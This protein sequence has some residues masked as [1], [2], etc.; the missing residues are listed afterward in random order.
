VWALVE[1]GLSGWRLEPRLVAPTVFAIWLLLPWVRRSLRSEPRRSPKPALFA[2]RGP[3]RR[4]S[5]AERFAPLAT[6][7]PAMLAILALIVGF[8]RPEG[9]EGKAMAA[10]ALTRIAKEKASGFEMPELVVLGVA[11]LSG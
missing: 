4:R 5:A 1:V 10:R 3:D 11:A 7:G 6:A 9:V 8:T 2:D